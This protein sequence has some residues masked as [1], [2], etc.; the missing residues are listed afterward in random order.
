M[1]CMHKNHIQFKQIILHETLMGF[2]ERKSTFNDWIQDKW[3]KECAKNIYRMYNN[4]N[5]I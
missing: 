5:E 3:K 1:I 2:K 4:N